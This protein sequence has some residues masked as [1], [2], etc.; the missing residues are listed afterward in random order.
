MA[1][2]Y[3]SCHVDYIYIY[4]YIYIIGENVRVCVSAYVRVC[5]CVHRYVVKIFEF[6]YNILA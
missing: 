4:I 2:I 6:S 5:V 1:G 3:D